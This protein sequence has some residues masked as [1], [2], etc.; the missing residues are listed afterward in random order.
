MCVVAPQLP[1]LY[2]SSGGGAP[3][4]VGKQWPSLTLS[5]SAMLYCGADAN[6][7]PSYT[8]TYEYW[9]ESNSSAT[10][11]GSNP[12]LSLSN[13]VVFTTD[14]SGS[15]FVPYAPSG[16]VTRPTWAALNATALGVSA[17]T[18]ANIACKATNT[19]GSR[20]AAFNVSLMGTRA[21]LAELSVVPS[22]F[23]LVSFRRVRSARTVLF[24][25]FML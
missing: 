24:L 14:T 13:V 17:S 15:V 16:F 1:V 2:Y 22:R 7:A 19:V 6:P 12:F 11:W 4:A 5:A 20:T 23:R 10:G 9:N 25:V 8:L 3:A 18:D 21:S